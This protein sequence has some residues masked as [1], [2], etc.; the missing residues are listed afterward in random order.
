MAPRCCAGEGRRRRLARRLSGAAASLLPGVGLAL[1]P[2]CPMCLAAWLTLLTGVGVSA[3]A[4]ARIRGLIVAFLVGALAFA[5]LLR[6]RR[7]L[8][9]DILREYPP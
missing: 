3:A 5:S 2:K 1:L 7:A 9:R 8:R 6:V 4:A